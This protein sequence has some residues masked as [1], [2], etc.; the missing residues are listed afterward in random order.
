MNQKNFLQKPNNS[1]SVVQVDPNS[2]TTID[3]IKTLAAN[4]QDKRVVTAAKKALTKMAK[5]ERQQRRRD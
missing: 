1:Y 2:Q 3:A 4:H 5:A